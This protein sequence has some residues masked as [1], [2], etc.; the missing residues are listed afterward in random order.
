M[1]IVSPD[2]PGR[3]L[4]AKRRDYAEARIPEYWVVSPIDEVIAVLILAGDA[5]AEHGV[6]RRGQRAD[7]VY[8]NS[9]AVRVAEVFDAA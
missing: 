4:Q 2:D 7:S 3:D 5:Y 1:E 9:F 8:L 6:F